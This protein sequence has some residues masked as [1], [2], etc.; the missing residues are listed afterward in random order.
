MQLQSNCLFVLV[1]ALM[2]CACQPPAQQTDSANTN[3][4]KTT[5]I[6]AISGNPI[7]DARA[8][9][10]AGDFRFKAITDEHGSP[11]VPSASRLKA[12]EYGYAYEY[13][14]IYTAGGKKTSP[15]LTDKIYYYA[16]N[17][18]NELLSIMRVAARKTASPAV[19]RN[20]VAPTTQSA[21]PV[22]KK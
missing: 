17:Y 10:D 11:V 9:A 19:S 18:N 20:T 5:N 15:E 14:L 8:A 13:A 3:A 22:R 21:N 2:F 4:G 1:C 12:E 6:P 7:N 16:S